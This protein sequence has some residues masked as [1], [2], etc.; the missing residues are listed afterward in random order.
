L[1]AATHSLEEIRKYVGADTLG[2]LSLEGLLD[3]VGVRRQHYCTSCYT[4][5]YPVA[6]PRDENAYLQLTLKLDGTRTAL[7]EEEPESVV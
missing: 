1:I 2:Y 6:F 5:Q 3:A 7:P 4:G